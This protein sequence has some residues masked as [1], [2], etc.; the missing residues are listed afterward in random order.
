MVGVEDKLRFLIYQCIAS[1]RYNER[2]S[3]FEAGVIYNFWY[4]EY[5]S[6]KQSIKGLFLAARC[7]YM[8]FLRVHA[9]LIELQNQLKQL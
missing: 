1:L 5:K 3:P 2:M 4:V 7:D 6:G 8:Q 9:E